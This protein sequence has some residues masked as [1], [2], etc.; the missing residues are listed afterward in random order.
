[1]LICAACGALIWL[2]WVCVSP[3][4][5]K[6]DGGITAE[7]NINKRQTV[8]G[9]VPLP[10]FVILPIILIM[11]G[12]ILQGVLRDGVTNW[13]PS[14]LNETFGMPEENAIFSTVILAI[15]SVVSFAV[16]DLVQ[17]KL[18]KNEV[19]CASMIFVLSFRAYL[20]AISTTLHHQT[21]YLEPKHQQQQ[22]YHV[23]R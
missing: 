11:L 2:F 10:K 19:F 5:L 15:F 4:L 1:M 16:F 20:R 17:R 7:A 8:Q 13:M 23:H 3:R 9:S 22:G 18:F 6:R 21:I 14:F 12:I